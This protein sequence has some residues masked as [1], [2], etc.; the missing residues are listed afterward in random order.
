MGEKGREA[1][2]CTDA[3]GP[4]PVGSEVWSPQDAAYWLA[5]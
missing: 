2:R 5:M 3:G 4:G 1:G